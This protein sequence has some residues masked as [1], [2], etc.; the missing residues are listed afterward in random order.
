MFYVL[1]LFSTAKRQYKYTCFHQ[2]SEIMDLRI[3]CRSTGSTACSLLIFLSIW[4]W[5]AKVVG[6]AGYIGKL[7]SSG[8]LDGEVSRIVHK[9]CQELLQKDLSAEVESF[10]IPPG[11]R[12]VYFSSCTNTSDCMMDT[13]CK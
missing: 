1:C 7:F 11:I 8:S 13:L 10:L 4:R 5:L 9:L 3:G 6:D 2:V 12:A